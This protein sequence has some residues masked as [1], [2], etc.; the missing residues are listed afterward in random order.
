[1]RKYLPAIILL[2]SS[3]NCLAQGDIGIS[4]AA[5]VPLQS[6]AK[7]TQVAHQAVFSG[8]FRLPVK[9]HPYFFAG[10]EFGIGNYAHKTI[11]QTFTFSD[12]STTLTDVR[13]NSNIGYANA[14]FR[15]DIPFKGRVVPYVNLKGGVTGLFTGIYVE[16]PKN[17]G[18]CEALDKSTAFKDATMTYTYGGGFRI[19]LSKQL[20]GR[21]SYL[22]DL[23]VNNTRG[24]TIDYLNVKDLGSHDHS[25]MGGTD[26]DGGKPLTTKFINVNTQNIHEHQLAEI[27]S[28]PV[29]LLQINLGLFIKFNPEGVKA[30]KKAKQ[31]KAKQHHSPCHAWRLG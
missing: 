5:G 31:P 20:N 29:R 26:P 15:Y 22:L 25:T 2:L 1:M 8:T 14:V 27:Y 24:G 12:G 7:H 23:G 21:H 9:K 3:L 16:D 6:L 28:S 4:Y 10:F 13:Y 17:P 18:G 30:P 11:E 19:N